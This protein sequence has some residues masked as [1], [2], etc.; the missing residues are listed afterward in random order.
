M[1]RPIMSALPGCGEEV[2]AESNGAPQGLIPTETTR[3]DIGNY[4]FCESSCP[5]G[6]SRKT[7]SWISVRTGAEGEEDNEEAEGEAP[8]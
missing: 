5:G 7:T 8:A 3:M 2:D 4:G 1:A 6:V